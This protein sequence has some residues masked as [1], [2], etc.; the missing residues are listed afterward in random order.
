MDKE[1]QR[2]CWEKEQKMGEELRGVEGRKGNST[3]MWMTR[4]THF[5]EVSVLIYQLNVILSREFEK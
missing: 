1:R 3:M 5:C 4:M 2:W